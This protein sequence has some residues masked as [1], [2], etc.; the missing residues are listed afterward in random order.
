MA[1]LRFTEKKDMGR[2][3]VCVYIYI[4]NVCVWD[5]N[6][7]YKMCLYK[8]LMCSGL[9][10]AECD[11]CLDNPRK[12]CKECSCCRCGD[13]KDPEKQLMCDECDMAY[14]LYCLEPP[15]TEIPDDDEW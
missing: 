14:H 7:L 12:K 5:V 9:N 11:H 10:K 6:T 1:R 8:V 13:K 4:Y 15:L 2:S 3:T